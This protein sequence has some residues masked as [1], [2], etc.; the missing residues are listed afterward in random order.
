MKKI[1]SLVLTLV[2]GV[3]MVIPAYAATNTDVINELKAGFKVNGVQKNIPNE[4]IKVAQDFLDSNNLTSAQLDELIEDGRAIKKEWQATG[5]VEF[6]NLPESVR[7]KLMNMAS[8][9][10]KKVGATISFDGKN[11][12]I[13]D[14]N[15]RTYQISLRNPIKTTG[16]DITN[17]VLLGSVFLVIIAAASIIVIKKR[18]TA[19]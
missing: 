4:Y 6:R 18:R 1:L 9:A 14:K 11:I 2:I 16:S 7:N 5:I 15:G 19:D 13:K 10:A 8:E 17:I 3:S 12:Q